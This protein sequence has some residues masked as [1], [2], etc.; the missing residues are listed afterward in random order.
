MEGSKIQKVGQL[1]RIRPISR[2][3]EPF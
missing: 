2:S 3:L 1:I